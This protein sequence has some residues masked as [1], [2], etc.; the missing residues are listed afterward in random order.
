LAF[1][2]RTKLSSRFI[3]GDLAGD[4]D[5]ESADKRGQHRELLR[6]SINADNPMVQYVREMIAPRAASAP[7]QTAKEFLAEMHGVQVDT[8]KTRIAKEK[9]ARVAIPPD[10][11][12]EEQVG[13]RHWNVIDA[14]RKQR[15]G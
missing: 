4:H 11:P 13:T 14:W 15:G 7:A 2:Y 1:R 10:V 5:E 6:M 12:P 9:A 3:W 8:I